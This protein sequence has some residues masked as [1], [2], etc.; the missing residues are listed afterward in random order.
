M[1]HHLPEISHMFEELVRVL[2]P[3]GCALFFGEPAVPGTYWWRRF[4]RWYGGWFTRDGQP[5]SLPETGRYVRARYPTQSGWQVSV[6]NTGL[7]SCYLSFLWYPFLLKLK[8]G[9]LCDVCHELTKALTVVDDRIV[10][11]M[12]PRFACEQWVVV[13]RIANGSA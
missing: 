9:W 2:K 1:L 8:S 6:L 11:R 5:P 7:L 12:V 10:P 3:D 13:R 4:K